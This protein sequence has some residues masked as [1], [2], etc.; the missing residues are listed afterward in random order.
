[1]K[2]VEE[3]EVLC[4]QWRRKVEWSEKWRNKGINLKKEERG[5]LKI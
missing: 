2:N 3:R 1:M 4:S 5:S